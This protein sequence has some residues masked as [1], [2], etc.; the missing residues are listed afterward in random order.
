MTS[1]EE[2]PPISDDHIGDFWFASAFLVRISNWWTI[3]WTILKTNRI[4]DLRE[5]LGNA[6]TCAFL[7]L[8]F[9][10]C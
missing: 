7:V 10:R 2:K 1:D 9:V 6:N 8:F 3:Y 5:I 4:E